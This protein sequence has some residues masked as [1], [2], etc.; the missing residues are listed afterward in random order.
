MMQYLAHDDG[1]IHTVHVKQLFCWC[2]IISRQAKEWLFNEPLRLFLHACRCSPWIALRSIS[3]YNIMYSTPAPPGTSPISLSGKFSKE[4]N[5]YVC[6]MFSSSSCLCIIS[7]VVFL[8]RLGSSTRQSSGY[9]LRR[10]LRAHL[11]AIMHMTTWVCVIVRLP[12]N[13]Q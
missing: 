5:H 7:F 10:E 12:R 2:D 9:P 11:W 8:W 3:T 4:K 13:Y 6:I 1:E